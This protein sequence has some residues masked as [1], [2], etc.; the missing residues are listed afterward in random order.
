MQHTIHTS[1]HTHTT[2]HKK[3]IELK[4]PPPTV[5][6]KTVCGVIAFKSLHDSNKLANLSQV[7]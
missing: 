5:Q 2:S 6:N 4:L 7:C 3:A 1:T